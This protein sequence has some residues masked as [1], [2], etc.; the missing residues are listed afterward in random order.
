[1]TWLFQHIL[2]AAALAAREA[3]GASNEVSI[4]FSREHG[5]VSD[6]FS[7]IFSQNLLSVLGC[8]YP[9]N[10]QCFCPTAAEALSTASSWIAICA[11]TGC[12]SGDAAADFT[13]MHSIYASYC[14]GAGVAQPGATEWLTTPATTLDGGTVVDVSTVTQT[15]PPNSGGPVR[16]QSQGWYKTFSVF[17]IIIISSV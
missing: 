15:L 8:D 12:S 2:V 3:R 16:T 13:T 6:C 1:M 7:G 5:C 9:F 4:S 11:S 10:N 14:S 17:V